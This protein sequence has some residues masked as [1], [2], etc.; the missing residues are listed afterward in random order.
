MSASA[1][2]RQRIVRTSSRHGA[3]PRARDGRDRTDPDPSPTLDCPS[4]EPRQLE[5][6]EPNP[7]RRQVHRALAEL[8][9]HQRTLIELA[10]WSELSQSEIATHLDISLETF[11]TR[12]RVALACLADLLEREPQERSGGRPAPVIEGR[13]ALPDRAGTNCQRGGQ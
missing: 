7:I 2:S 12:A 3:V 1:C 10:Y 4:E 9:E 6:A 13:D 11:K 8:P 5:H